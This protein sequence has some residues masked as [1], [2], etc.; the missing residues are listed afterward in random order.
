MLG[1]HG[2]EYEE[3]VFWTAAPFSPVEVYQRL[4][5]TC[6]LHNLPDG[7]GSKEF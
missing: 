7:G 3:A 1:S 5:G 6:S 2:G 4:S